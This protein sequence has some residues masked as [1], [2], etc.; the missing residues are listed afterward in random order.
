MITVEKRL[1]IDVPGAFNWSWVIS[2]NCVKIISD[3]LDDN[4]LLVTQFEFLN[5]A[6]LD[7]VP[8]LTFILEGEG[9]CVIE[10]T[11]PF[12]YDA[13][14]VCGSLSIAA[15]VQRNSDTS[16]QGQAIGGVAPYDYKWEYDSKCYE[17]IDGGTNTLLSLTL[18]EDENAP[19]SHDV[20]LRVVDSLG[21]IA[22]A[23]LAFSPCR[24]VGDDALA[25]LKAVPD[26]WVSAPV[27]L[28]VTDCDLGIV[29]ALSPQPFDK[30]AG[31]TPLGNSYLIDP[32][33]LA[34]SGGTSIPSVDEAINWSTLL[35]D[36]IPAGVTMKTLSDGVIS[37]SGSDLVPGNYLGSWSVEDSR[38]NRS[39]LGII[40]FSIEDAALLDPGSVVF[41]PLSRR[42]KC[43]MKV[44]DKLFFAVED[45][46][47]NDGTVDLDW[48]TFKFIPT[49]GITY[50]GS[51]KVQTDHG[52]I[53]LDDN[54]NIIY[55]ILS[56]GTPFA[57]NVLFAIADTTGERCYVSEGDF[58]FSST[59]S[60]CPEVM[61][62]NLCVMCGSSVTVDIRDVVVGSFD[63]LSFTLV[64]TDQVFDGSASISDG[65]FTYDSN[66]GFTG[67]VQATYTVLDFS[68]N[69]SREGSILISVFCVDDITAV[70]ATADN[71]TGG[72]NPQTVALFSLLTGA[73]NTIG[74][75]F[76][77]FVAET[78]SPAGVIDIGDGSIEYSTGDVLGTTN[79]VTVD[80]AGST[81]H[82]NRSPSGT[83]TFCYTRG[84][85]ACRVK[86]CLSITVVDIPNP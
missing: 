57:D 6:C 80:F 66:D 5:K 15:G 21:C 14:E 65:V 53:T 11:I 85:G 68:G 19:S 45:H 59:C 28:C 39:D 78:G 49:A 35:V 48:N 73:D 67:T 64:N 32:R 27:Y 51:R 52:L 43:N 7:G 77:S 9:G 56:L 50:L 44:G 8:Q 2:N 3:N 61:D 1:Q 25:V 29:F 40:R 47:I 82:G 72:S 79:L 4:G 60:G 18:K 54:R 17:V 13:Q 71:W 55:E 36:G 37:F 62:I 34:S 84:T 86:G 70:N 22:Q 26:G 41:L 16:F 58:V 12:D 10:K 42:I 24:P 46:I 69:I 81:G 20:S 75:E 38:G 33:L 31:S 74:W 63:P 83:Y 23:S 30:T 76:G